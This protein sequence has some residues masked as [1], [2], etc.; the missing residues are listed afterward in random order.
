MISCNEGELIRS[1]LTVD[2]LLV[3]ISAHDFSVDSSLAT[4]I[5][6]CDKNN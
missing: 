3:I 5:V 1:R 2:I 4:W 6:S